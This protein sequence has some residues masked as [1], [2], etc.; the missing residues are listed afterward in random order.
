[1]I[2]TLHK[3]IDVYQE[4]LGHPFKDCELKNNHSKLG[5]KHE[6]DHAFSRAVDKIQNKKESELT[7]PE[8]TACKG[9]LKR[10]HLN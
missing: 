7:N 6:T 10:N 5:N 1:M 4:R 2:D 8:K 3:T 9:L